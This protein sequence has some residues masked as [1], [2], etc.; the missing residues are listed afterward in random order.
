MVRI[1]V[2]VL[3]STAKDTRRFMFSAA[4]FKNNP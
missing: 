4:H 1:I 3:Y 2:V